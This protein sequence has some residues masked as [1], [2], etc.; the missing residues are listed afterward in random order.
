M[1]ILRSGRLPVYE[2]KLPKPPIGNKIFYTH[3]VGMFLLERGPAVWRCMSNTHIGSGVIT[4]VDG[5]PDDNG[6]FPDQDVHFTD[7]ERYAKANGKIIFQSNPAVMG[8]WMEDGFC[9]NGLTI[10]LRGE[11]KAVM[12]CV[13]VC[14]L[15]HTEPAPRIVADAP[16][17][18]PE[19]KTDGRKRRAS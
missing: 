12:P 18:L 10:I 17:Q 5:V 9:W 6:F 1:P 15:P 2:V 14:W 8:M 16:I 19:P 7:V 4:V 3:E 13:S 11:H